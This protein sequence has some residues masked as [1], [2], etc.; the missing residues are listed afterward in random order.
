MARRNDDQSRFSPVLVSRRMHIRSG[1]GTNEVVEPFL[2]V[3]VQKYTVTG[4][5]RRSRNEKRN[6]DDKGTKNRGERVRKG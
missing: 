6:A 5:E 4:E 1:T 3:R 2:R